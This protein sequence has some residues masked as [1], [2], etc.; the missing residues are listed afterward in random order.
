MYTLARAT[1]MASETEIGAN[2]GRAESLATNGSEFAQPGT[3]PDPEFSMSVVV[4][5]LAQRPMPRMRSRHYGM[6]WYVT[7]AKSWNGLSSPPALHGVFKKS[8][9]SFFPWQHL[10]RW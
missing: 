8:T 6:S 3:S 9:V 2:Q 1:G 7:M 4:P 5:R 10:S